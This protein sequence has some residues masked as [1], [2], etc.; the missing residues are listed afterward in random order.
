LYV[1]SPHM[2]VTGLESPEAG[3]AILEMLLTHATSPSFTYFHAWQVG[4]VIV[5]DNT[6]TLHHAMPYKNDGSAIRE[7]YR[8]QARLRDLGDEPATIKQQD[9]L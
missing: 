9:E 7:L 4:D 8:T 5:W 2:A 1:G 6:Q 3:K